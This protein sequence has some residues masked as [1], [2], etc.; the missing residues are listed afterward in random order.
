MAVVEL[1]DR[2]EV[3]RKKKVKIEAATGE[4][5]TAGKP[6]AADPFAK[7]RKVFAGGKKAAA[8]PAAEKKTKKKAT[9]KSE[10]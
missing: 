5:A 1:V 6:V 4:E 8:K 7:M 10:A 3:D 9:K 2:P